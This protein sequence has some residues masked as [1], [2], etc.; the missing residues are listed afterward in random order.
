MVSRPQEITDA[1]KQLEA[2]KSRLEGEL[3]VFG[4]R[5]RNALKEIRQERRR[6]ERE[7]DSIHEGLAVFGLATKRK[8]RAKKPGS[9]GGISLEQATTWITD[10]LKEQKSLTRKELQDRIKT[11]A[12][13]AG[14][15]ASGSH[16]VLARALKTDAFTEKNGAYSLN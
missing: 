7:L 13:T 6:V 10:A 9:A 8:K 5:E 3:K 11:S 12:K 15:K 14:K 16:L 4:Q 1:I 2:G